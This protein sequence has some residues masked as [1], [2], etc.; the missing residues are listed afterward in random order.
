[1]L[2]SM[3][4]GCAV[5]VERRRQDS[6]NARSQHARSLGLAHLRLDDEKA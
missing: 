4:A 3:L 6:R 2:A 1:M 5:K